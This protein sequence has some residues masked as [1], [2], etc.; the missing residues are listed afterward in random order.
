MH[1]LVTSLL[2][3]ALTCADPAP[4]GPQAPHEPNVP[5][6]VNLE[7]GTASV[8]PDGGHGVLLGLDARRWTESGEKPAAPRRFVFLFD[9]SVRF[10]A[11]GFPTCDRAQLDRNACPEGSRVGS[12]RAE[13]YPAGTAEVVVYNTRYADGTRGM[14]ITIPAVGTVLENTFEKVSRPYRDRYTWASDEIF[15]PST[16]PPQDRP[17]T[18]RFAITFGATHQGRSYVRTTTPVGAP[19][20]FGVHSEYVTGQ[21]TLTETTATRTG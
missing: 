13:F 3:T 6:P 14:L 11:A 17:V 18:Q 21:R 16:V 7:E 8:T 1:A 20:T 4:T 15:P 19:M 10:D 9:D 12:G 5:G 2:V